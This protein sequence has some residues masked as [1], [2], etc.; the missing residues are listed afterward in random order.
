MQL[1]LQ[2]C[3]WLSL[4]IAAV[5]LKRLAPPPL[6]LLLHRM[7]MCDSHLQ[8]ANDPRLIEGGPLADLVTKPTGQ[9]STAIP[10]SA[11]P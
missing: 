9:N 10:M 8:V 3:C 4:T 7:G 1:H 2:H 5:Q 6:L 11:T